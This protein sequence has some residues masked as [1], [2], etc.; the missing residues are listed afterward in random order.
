MLF[1]KRVGKYENELFQARKAGG[2]FMSGLHKIDEVTE[3]ISQV[4]T[5]IVKRKNR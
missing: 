2:D 1:D 5:E 3:Y 4:A